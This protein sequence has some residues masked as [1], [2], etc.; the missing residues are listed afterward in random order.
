NIFGN[1]NVNT[2][3]ALNVNTVAGGQDSDSDGLSDVEE[4]L[5][6]TS[7]SIADTDSDSFADGQEVINGYNPNGSGA[8]TA[9]T[10]IRSFFDT[11]EGYSVYYPAG[12]V[13]GSDP[14]DERG[15]MISTSGEFITVNVQENPARLA[16]RDWYLSKSPGIDSAR[17][18]T[19]QNWDK[20]LLGAI[21]LDG[22]T[23]YYSYG[24]NEYVISYNVNILSQADYKTI[25]EMLYKSFAI[26]TSTPTNSNTNASSNSNSNTN[27][28]TNLNS[29][30][31][32]NTNINS[33]TNTNN[34][35]NTNSIIFF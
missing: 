21:S 34:N 33:N 27:T 7:I 30:S 31:N 20:T 14:Q 8:L 9:T 2:N 29:N 3:T 10:Y 25:F 1:T 16:A 17:I 35:S 24:I 23:V 11:E 6:G 5:F 12:W 26:S 28:N 18:V 13:V 19:F 4:S 32:T 22:L 15:T